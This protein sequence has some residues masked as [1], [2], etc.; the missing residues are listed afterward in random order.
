M[1]EHYSDMK[2]YIGF[3]VSHSDELIIQDGLGD[4]YDVGEQSPGFTQNTPIALP[5]TA[6]FYHIVDIIRQIAALLGYN[7]DAER[8]D[9]LCS[10][11]KAAY[12]AAFFDPISKQYSSGSQAAQAMS[13]ALGLV[14]E[15]YEPDVLS[16]LV[17]DIIARGYH[18]SSG[19]IAHRFVLLALSQHNRNDVILKMSRQTE[20]PSYGY[21]IVHGATSLTEAWDGPT[22]GKSQNHFMLGHLE[23]WFYRDLAGIDYSYNPDTEA[24]HYAVKPYF[25]ESLTFVKSKIRA[26]LG[27]MSVEW[28]RSGDGSLKLNLTIPAN[29][30]AT[31]RLPFSYPQKIT[32]NGSPIEAAVGIS[33]ERYEPGWT[34]LQLAS[35]RYSFS[36][37]A[38]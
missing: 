2:R 10:R 1:I 4:W 15:E 29:S 33:L 11:I 25:E 6:M 30:T 36:V 5:E 24:I 32:E 31:V 38:D 8:F 19:D 37:A 21:Q 13:L 17:S 20:H 16:H 28:E 3:L 9:S 35:G 18:T 14:G 7:D 22:V 27:D 34:V 12:N 23:E 26:D